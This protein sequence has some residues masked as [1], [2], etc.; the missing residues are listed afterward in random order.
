MVLPARRG[1]AYGLF[2]SFYGL[3]WFL[4]SAALGL[5]YDV[6]LLALIAGS[7]GIQLLAAALLLLIARR[8]RA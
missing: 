8:A 4:G 1:T 6:S 5:L 7:V 3:T 2:N